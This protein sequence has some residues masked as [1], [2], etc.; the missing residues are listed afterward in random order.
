MKSATTYS[1]IEEWEKAF[2][3]HWLAEV[4]GS[5][6]LQNPHAY[7]ENSIAELTQSLLVTHNTKVGSP[8]RSQKSSVKA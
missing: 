3:P 2:F 7:A 4:E 8:L 5:K 6:L 1:S